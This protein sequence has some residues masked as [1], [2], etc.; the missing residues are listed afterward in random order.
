MAPSGLP[1]ASVCLGCICVLLMTFYFHHTPLLAAQWARVPTFLMTS[2]GLPSMWLTPKAYWEMADTLHCSSLK[3]HDVFGRLCGHFPIT[4]LSPLAG[5]HTLEL[6]GTARRHLQPYLL[7]CLPLFHWHPALRTIKE[8]GE[9]MFGLPSALCKFQVS[10]KRQASQCTKCPM[11]QRLV[12]GLSL[13]LR[14]IFSVWQYQ[15]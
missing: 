15:S 12:I 11:P 5:V 9:H 13:C 8:C 2:P 3:H 6:A 1:R 14:G 4:C 10:V 7:G